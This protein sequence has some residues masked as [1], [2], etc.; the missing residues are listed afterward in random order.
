[1]VDNIEDVDTVVG[2]LAEA[3]A[4]ARLRHLGDA[5]PGLHPE[6]V[7]AAVQRP[8]LHVE[9]PS[10]VLLDARPPLGHEQR[11][12]EKQFEPGAPNGY[13]RYEVSPLKRVLLRTIPELEAELEGVVNVFDPWARDRG[14]FYGLIR[15]LVWRGK[16]FRS[17]RSGTYLKNLISPLSLELFRAEVY[18]DDSWF[19]DGRAIVLD[20]S[21]SSFLV[22]MIRDEIRSVGNGVYLG[23]V[24]LGRKRVFLFMLEFPE[25]VADDATADAAPS[26]A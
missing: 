6:R 2:W 4:P 5:V 22:R 26:R 17:G 13:E 3:R 14:E 12:G 15:L 9:L 25:P 23:Q 21:K 16:T 24:F 1:V 10:R 7:P 11:P 8:V 20:Y 18:E 19:D